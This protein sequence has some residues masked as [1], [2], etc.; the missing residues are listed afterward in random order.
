MT[1]CPV[2]IFRSS[3]LTRCQYFLNRSFLQGMHAVNNASSLFLDERGE[4]SEGGEEGGGGGGPAVLGVSML[5][6]RAVLLEVQVGYLSRLHY[7]TQ[8][9]HSYRGLN[10]CYNHCP[11]TLHPFPST[12]PRHPNRPC[13]AAR[14]TTRP[15]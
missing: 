10:G 5:G 13:A 14:T 4:G 1:I 15:L 11:L 9:T 6:N 12:P 2:A 8:S 3:R 7:H